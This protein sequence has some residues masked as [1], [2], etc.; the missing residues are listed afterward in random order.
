[1]IAT[2]TAIPVNDISPIAHY[3]NWVFRCPNCGDSFELAQ[4]LPE[5]QEAYENQALEYF[6]SCGCKAVANSWLEALQRGEVSWK[7]PEV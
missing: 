1:M 4:N 2:N 3:P 7:P 5:V 6:R